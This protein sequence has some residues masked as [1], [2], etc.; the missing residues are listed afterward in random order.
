MYVLQQKYENI[1]K[2]W[3]KAI[4]PLSL[5]QWMEF[6]KLILYIPRQDV[7][8]LWLWPLGRGLQVREMERGKGI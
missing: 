4:K 8:L 7:G 2:E 1:Q 6:S 5:F 3:Y